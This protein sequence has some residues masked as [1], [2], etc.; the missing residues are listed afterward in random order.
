LQPGWTRRARRGLCDV[1]RET[2]EQG[3]LREELCAYYA[4]LLTPEVKAA[5]KRPGSRA[6]RG[7]DTVRRIGK[8]G[9]LG[10]GWPTE[11]GGQG[12]PATDQFIFFDETR[13][14]ARRSPS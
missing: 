10:I 2:P 5:S 8:D 4:E 11:F 1:P 12:R 13:R 14:L 9:W 7:A 6:R 3:E